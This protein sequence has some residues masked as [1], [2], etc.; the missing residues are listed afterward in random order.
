MND[1]VAIII[2]ARYNSKRFPGKPLAKIKNVTVIERVWKI[3]KKVKNADEV[4]IATDNTKIFEHCKKLDLN[5]VMTPES[6]KNGTERVASLVSSKNFPYHII[7]NFQ[8]DAL[9]TPPWIIEKTINEILNKKTIEICTP[10]VLMDEKTYKKLIE[11][12]KLGIIG[13]TTVTFSKSYKALYF[14]KNIIPFLRYKYGDSIRLYKHI[15]LYVYRKDMLLKLV[16][17]PQTPLEKCE[18]LEQLRALENDIPIHIVIVDY[19]GR[20]AWSIDNP[21]DISIIE[22]IIEKEGDLLE[23]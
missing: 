23:L 14:S 12:K 20:T 3:A 13:G 21:E 2:P 22:N 9:L 10:A 19:K 5:V 16:K 1:K 8:G 18:G 4:I 6:C 15:G 17:L 7:V 11:N